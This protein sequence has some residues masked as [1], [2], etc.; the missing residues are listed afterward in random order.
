MVRTARA[1]CYEFGEEGGRGEKSPELRELTELSTY[2]PL[3]TYSC[4]GFVFLRV[5]NYEQKHSNTQNGPGTV[6]KIPS[7][8]LDQPRQSKLTPLL[9]TIHPGVTIACASR[10]RAF[11]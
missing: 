2:P 1:F 9:T 6:P 4:G 10:K 11:R 8:L 3:D 7:F 5:T